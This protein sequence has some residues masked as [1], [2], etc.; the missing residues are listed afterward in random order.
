MKNGYNVSYGGGGLLGVK[1]PDASERM[2]KNNPMFNPETSKKVSSKNSKKRIGVSWKDL[3]YD[4]EINKRFS[5]R[6]K[7]NNP[8]F[9]PETVKRV[10]R[11]RKENGNDFKS[12]SEESKK[13][14]SKS[15]SKN[16]IIIYPDGNEIQISNLLNFCKN[17]NLS[18]GHMCEVSK[19]RRIQHKGHRCRRC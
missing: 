14:M 15:K 2:K 9:N 18:C 8:M 10:V 16:W 17:N 5:E 4:E 12:H 1:R 7:K 13:K 11:T 6:M 3:N 19:G